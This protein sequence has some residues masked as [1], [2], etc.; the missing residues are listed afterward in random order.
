LVTQWYDERRLRVGACSPNAAHHA[1]AE[2]QKTALERGASF[3]LITQNVDRLHQRAGSRDVVELHGSLFEWRCTKSGQRSEITGP[4]FS[5]YPPRSTAG[6]LL[7]PGVVWFGEMLD[8]EILGLAEHRALACDL[9]IAI[10]TSSLIYP[11]AG[12]LHLARTG[13]ATTIEINKDPTPVSG[14]VD[15]VIHGRAGEI[16][17]RI[18]RHMVES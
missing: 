16:L 15:Y 11:A 9:F 5:E 12:L 13:G 6:G 7:R 1:L 8:P 17:P 18:V 3:A 2:I 4:A 14:L 10:G